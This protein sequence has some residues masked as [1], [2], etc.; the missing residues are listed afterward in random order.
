MMRDTNP[1][2]SSLQLAGLAPHVAGEVVRDCYG[3]PDI[4]RIRDICQ[5]TV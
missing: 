1:V 2:R 3:N 4:G 5:A